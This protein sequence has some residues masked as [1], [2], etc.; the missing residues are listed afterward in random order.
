MRE[1]GTGQQ[2]AQLNDRYMLVMMIDDDDDDELLEIV[3]KQTV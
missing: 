2:V 3:F 1:T